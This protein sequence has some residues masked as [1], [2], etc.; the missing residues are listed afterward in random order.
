MSQKPRNPDLAGWMALAA[1]SE[2]GRKAKAK[3][4]PASADYSVVKPSRLA[5]RK[6]RGR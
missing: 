3:R 4:R 1:N 2:A 5:R 6:G